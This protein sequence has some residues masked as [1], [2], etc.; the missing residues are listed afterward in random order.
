MYG[1]FLAHFSHF[2]GQNIISKRSSSVMHGPLRPCWVPEK[3]T[4]PIPRKILDGRMDRSYSE[5]LL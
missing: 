3:T 4:E 1:L 5:A 2:G